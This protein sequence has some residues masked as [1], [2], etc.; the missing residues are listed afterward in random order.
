MKK[1][2]LILAVMLT[3]SS[4]FAQETKETPA[5]TTEPEAPASKFAAGVDV[6]APYLWRGIALN[7]I[8][9]VA[10]QPYASYAFTD[11]LTFGVWGTT[12]V[13]SDD[14]SYNEVDWYVSYQATKVIKLMLSDY[15]YNATKKS[16]GLRNG[17]FKYDENSPHVMDLSVLFD[18]SES[19]IPL[20]F[21]WNTLIYGNDFK[22]NSSGA[23]SRAFSSYAEAGYTY[24]IEKAGIDLRPFVGATVI[25]EGGYYGVDENGN[26]GFAF[27]NVGLNV[28]KEIKFS[29]ER[30]KFDS[31]NSIATEV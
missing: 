8:S 1:T 18:F 11:K 15:Y 23:K 22:Y 3:T 5:A 9:K 25:N 30:T 19:G 10:F 31:T 21:Q 12:N 28:A 17:Y 16:G 29:D 24:T 7:S 14:K 26:P 20:D 4:L 6:V 27:T 2:V 13:S